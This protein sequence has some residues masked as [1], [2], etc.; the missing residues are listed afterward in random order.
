MKF[1]CLYWHLPV[2]I[3]IYLSGLKFTCLYWNLPVHI[4]NYLYKFIC[5]CVSINLYDMYYD[6]SIYLYALY[7]LIQ[8][9]DV[10]R[11]SICHVTMITQG[12]LYPSWR[13]SSGG[14]E[15]NYANLKQEHSERLK[16]LW[17]SAN[18]LCT[19]GGNI[20]QMRLSNYM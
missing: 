5:I 13:S 20:H 7:V 16:N 11:D 2:Y 3:E 18:S 15:A 9:S 17:E 14:G 1:T 10:I 19:R 4:Q 6:L 12:L 8:V